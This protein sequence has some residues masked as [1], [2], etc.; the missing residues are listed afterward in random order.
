MYFRI[1]AKHS[2]FVSQHGTCFVSKGLFV[3]REAQ[4]VFV[5]ESSFT[6]GVTSAGEDDGGE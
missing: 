5:Y 4:T 3:K 6:H 2:N 1:E